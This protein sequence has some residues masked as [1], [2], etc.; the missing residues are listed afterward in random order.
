MKPVVAIGSRT[1]RASP[2]EIRNRYRRPLKRGPS[3]KSPRSQPP[4]PF[5]V[6]QFQ[7][8]LEAQQEGAQGLTLALRHVLVRQLGHDH[9]DLLREVAQQRLFP[10]RHLLP[11][12]LQL[13]DLPPLLRVRA[14]HAVLHRLLRLANALAL[15]PQQPGLS[16]ES[17]SKR[18]T[19]R[20]PGSTSTS[21]EPWPL[22]KLYIMHPR[23][24]G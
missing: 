10:R 18:A 12:H 22:E 11:L 24:S 20:A 7:S 17:R 14:Q 16:R 2:G 6:G 15:R 23:A 13:L 9:L 19:F 4:G 8:V 3:P 5:S 1:H 21:P